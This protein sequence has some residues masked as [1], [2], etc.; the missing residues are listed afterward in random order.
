[1]QP[2]LKGLPGGLDGLVTRS[3]SAARLDEL[4][5]DD[6]D[7]RIFIYGFSCAAEGGSVRHHVL[8]KEL[9]LASLRWFEVPCMHD[10]PCFRRASH[11]LMQWTWL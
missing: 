8:N 4:Q 11:E 10:A 7:C 9:F 5:G 2:D 1:M 6:L 3:P